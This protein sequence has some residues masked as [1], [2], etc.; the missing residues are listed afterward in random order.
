MNLSVSAIPQELLENANAVIRLNEKIIDLE[1]VDKIV[2]KGKRIITVLNKDGDHH[3]ALYKHYDNDTKISKLSVK[4]FDKNGSQLQKYSKNKF[5]DVSA[6]NGLYSDDRL[7]YLDY[8]PTVYPYTILFEYEISSKTTGFIKSWKPIEGY[9]ISTEKSSYKI[10]N[11]KNL[12]IRKKENNFK[13]FQIEN[14]SKENT[15]Y[16]TLQSQ[17][18]IKYE[19]H[20]LSSEKL[21]P[22]LNVS[23][24]QFSLKG[25]IANVSDWSEFGKWMRNNLYN[26]RLELSEA[27]KTIVRNLVK[28]ETNSI[29]KAKLIYEYMQNKTRYIYVGIGIGGWQ[30]SLAKDVDKLGYGDCKGLSN[31]TKALLD[32]AGVESYWTIVYAKN[33]KD[34]KKD[35]VSMQGNHMIINIPNEG[36]DIWL[37]C[38]SQIKP[39]GFLG[40]FTDDR[41]VLVLTDNGGVIKHTPAYKNETNLQKTQSNIQID[42]S[43]NIK[44]TVSIESKGIQYEDRFRIENNTKEE[45]DKYYKSSFWNYNNNLSIEKYNFTNDK[46]IVSFKEDLEVKIDNYATFVNTNLFFRV[47]I[48]NKYNNVPKR[49]RSRKQPLHIARGFKDEDTFVFSIT[50]GYSITNLPSEKILETKFGSYQISFEKIDDTNFKYNR[51]FLLKAGLYPKEDYNAYRNFIKSIAKNDNLKIELLKNNS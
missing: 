45:I 18:A 7:K 29:K 5:K 26:D 2:F 38:T 9:A 12:T 24:N 31:Y 27:T 50:K 49:Y 37:E 22:N 14:K 41:D 20:S 39:F 42:A 8:T 46:A 6:A 3:V 10:N 43:G 33:N 25:V 51:T 21:L 19:S 4:S 13:G 28:D 17:K 34:I 32:V 23:L 48:F 47:N 1:A 11:P 40:D 44:A 30:P 36:N 16:Y 35:F 15:P